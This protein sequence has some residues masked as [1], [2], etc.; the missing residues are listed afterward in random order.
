MLFINEDRLKYRCDEIPSV[1]VY[2]NYLHHLALSG[3]IASI[4]KVSSSLVSRT[5]RQ[6]ARTVPAS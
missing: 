3:T 5:L 6:M 2:S 4:Q 1:T